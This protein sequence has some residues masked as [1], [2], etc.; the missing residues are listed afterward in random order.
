MNAIVLKPAYVQH[1]EF[2]FVA[3]MP[4]KEVFWQIR[5]AKETNEHIAQ[6]FG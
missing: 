3:W 1:G 4:I 5:I 6:I 2:F